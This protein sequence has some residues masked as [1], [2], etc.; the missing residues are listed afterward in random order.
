MEHG[1]G[2][3]NKFSPGFSFW[4][5]VGN[6]KLKML[7]IFT[8]VRGCPPDRRLKSIKETTKRQDFVEIHWNVIKREKRKNN[9]KTLI[10]AFESILPN[11]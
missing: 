2:T 9:E 3:I 5:S 1:F 7:C 8:N 11:A 10:L 4:K 6:Y